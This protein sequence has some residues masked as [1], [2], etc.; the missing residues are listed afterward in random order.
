MQYT[1]KAEIDPKTLSQAAKMVDE[2]ISN[3]KRSTEKDE[4]RSAV[5]AALSFAIELNEDNGNIEKIVES[6]KILEEDRVNLKDELELSRDE[7]K[8]IIAKIDSSLDSDEEK[9]AK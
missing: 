8:N 9:L 6:Q 3:Y 2:R 7:L 1:L 5:L 4:L